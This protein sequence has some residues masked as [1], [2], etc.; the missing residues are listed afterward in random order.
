MLRNRVIGFVGIGFSLSL[1]R[2]LTDEKDYYRLLSKAE[3]DRYEWKNVDLKDRA[4]YSS[5]LSAT[6]SLATL[7]TGSLGWM[8]PGVILTGYCWKKLFDA[9][10][11]LD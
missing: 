3:Q 6:G 7:A 4:F 11:E 5:M 8:A 9:E 1:C 2:G 10:K